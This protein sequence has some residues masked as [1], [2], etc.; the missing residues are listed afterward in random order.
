M[1]TVPWLRLSSFLNCNTVVCK[2][3]QRNNKDLQQDGE[4]ITAMKYSSYRDLHLSPRD[5]LQGILWKPTKLLCQ[6]SLL[7]IKIRW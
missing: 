6:P 2:D 3:W 4:G 7:K 5:G 1:S